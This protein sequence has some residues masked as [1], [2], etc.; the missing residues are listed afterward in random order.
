M[1]EFWARGGVTGIHDLLMFHLFSL[2]AIHS[3]G[4]RGA[5]RVNFGRNL[6]LGTRVIPFDSAL[7]HD[8]RAGYLLGSG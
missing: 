6:E 3:I 2:A 8:A 5:Y 7:R 4:K 1:T